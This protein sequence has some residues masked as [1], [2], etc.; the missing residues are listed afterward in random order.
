MYVKITLHF[1]LYNVNAR[2][3][4]WYYLEV[5]GLNFKLLGLNFM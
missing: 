4:L 2:I 5:I 1:R 3:M